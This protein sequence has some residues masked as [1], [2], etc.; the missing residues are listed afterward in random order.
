MGSLGSFER[1]W[2]SC[3]ASWEE[4]AVYWGPGRIDLFI[5]VS[6]LE[7]VVYAFCRVQGRL[8]GLL[9]AKG[10][11]AETSVFIRVSVLPRGGR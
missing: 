11:I 7:G 9:G 3:F 8:G 2:A 10:F 5:E 4:E 6:R 1:E